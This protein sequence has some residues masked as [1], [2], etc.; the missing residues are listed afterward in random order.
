MMV[1]RVVMVMGFSLGV[2]DDNDHSGQADYPCHKVSFQGFSGYFLQ[3]SFSSFSTLLQVV[4]CAI[5]PFAC[6]LLFF[7]LHCSC[8]L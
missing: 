5:F 6:F 1:K 8:I 4:C 7:C 3:F 2:V